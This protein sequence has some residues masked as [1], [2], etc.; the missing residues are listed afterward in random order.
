VENLLAPDADEGA[1]EVSAEVPTGNGGGENGS[2]AE[3]RGGGGRRGCGEEAEK[4]GAGDTEIESGEDKPLF[5]NVAKLESIS[6]PP[7]AS[8]T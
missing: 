3:E 2:L 1:G 6:N 5:F 8:K 4:A 7:A